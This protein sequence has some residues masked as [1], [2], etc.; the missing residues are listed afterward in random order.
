VINVVEHEQPYQQQ[1]G[2]DGERSD[3]VRGVGLDELLRLRTVSKVMAWRSRSVRVCGVSRWPSNS[4][5]IAFPPR[6][7]T[8]LDCSI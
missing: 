2:N 4:R 1:P 7:A 6:R 3:G 8:R 5:A